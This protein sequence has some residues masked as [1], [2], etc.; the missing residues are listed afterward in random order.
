MRTF[1]I[2]FGGQVQ[3]VGFRPYV[4]ERASQMGLTG[5]VSNG[6][7]GVSIFVNGTKKDC[8][9]FYHELLLSPPANARITDH[10]LEEVADKEFESFSILPSTTESKPSLVLTPDLAM[11]SRCKEELHDTSNRRYQYA[12]TTCLHCG[13]RYSIIQRLP[14]DRENTTMNSFAMCN[15]CDGEYYNPLDQRHYSQTNSCPDCEITMSLLDENGKKI[16]SS[17]NQVIDEVVELINSGAI[18][19]LKGIGGFLLVCDASAPKT[20]VTLRERKH[21]PSKPFALLYPTIQMLKRDTCVSPDEERALTSKESPIVLLKMRSSFKS[22]FAHKLI[23]PHLS[24]IGVMLPYAPML[25]LIMSRLNKPVIATSANVSNSP[26]LYTNAKAIKDLNGVADYFVVNNRDIV[27]PQDDSVSQFTPSGRAIFLRRS[28]GYAPAYLPNPFNEKEATLAMGG[29]LKSAFALNDNE[30]LFVSQYL[31]DL[32][33]FDTQE[34]YQHTLN[35]LLN[36]FDIRLQ[37]IIVD[38]HP[39]YFS[40]AL[41][42]KLSEETGAELS[43]VQHH[44]AHFAAVLAENNLLAEKEGVLGVIWDGTGWGDDEAIWGGEFLEYSDFTIARLDHLTYLDHLLGDK[45]SLEPRISAFS[46]CKSIAGAEAFLKDKFTEREWSLYSQLARQP[47]LTQTSSMGRLFDGVASLLGLCDKSSYEGE[48]ALYLE[49]AAQSANAT[50][51]SP[52]YFGK[53]GFTTE[54]LL[55]HVIT[56][57][58]NKIPKEDI[59]YRFHLALVDWV[60]SIALLHNQ[61]RIAFSG[62]VFQNALLVELLTVQLSR[63][64]ELYFHQQLSPNDECI[65]FGQLAFAHIKR[66]RLVHTDIPEEFEMVL[67]Q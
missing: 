31:G 55:H 4:F 58:R 32:E 24:K 10:S 63:K 5:T 34:S 46:L 60:E 67:K 36:L 30:R 40:T 22:R 48:A 9:Q 20:I 37:Q 33:S 65:G 64:F 13:P 47:H 3:G 54:K 6:N 14:Y 28:R 27:V 19:A 16:T 52:W 53:D 26:I 56:D 51:I 23:A 25:E 41:G 12:F 44:H 43:F 18:I 15:Q 11:C 7:D 8:F 61:S 50:L 38:K 17:S 1:H 29:D 2:H 62:G 59:A 39:H 21:R 49:S 57:L 66:L 45:M 35:H 42:R